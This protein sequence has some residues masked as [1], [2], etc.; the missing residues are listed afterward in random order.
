MTA[1]LAA[2]LLTVLAGA[3]LW[4]SALGEPGPAERVHEIAA[5]LRCPDC[6]G[7][8]A[9]ESSSQMALSVRAEIERRL[10]AGQSADAILDHF[11]QRYGEWIRLSPGGDGLS[12]LLWILPVAALAAALLPAVRRR[13]GRGASAVLSA[14]PRPGRRGSAV[15]PAV[16]RRWASRVPDLPDAEHPPSAG[17]SRADAVPAVVLLLLGSVAVTGGAVAVWASGRIQNAPVAEETRGGGGDAAGRA[18][19]LAAAGDH[20]AAV[21]AYREALRQRPDDRAARYLMAFEL[22]RSGR[23]AEA[24]ALL[25]PLLATRPH[26]PDLL[27]VLGTAE[28]TTDPARGR[29]TLRRFLAAAPQGHAAAPRI[30]A[31]LRSSRDLPG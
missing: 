19:A 27:L 10:R 9:A 1:R 29:R 14:V 13:R 31:L 20:D 26:D 22:V 28:L 23:A 17:R 18:R 25:E 7:V 21:R 3:A 4:R 30:R 16:R 5:S 6:Q 2:L 8:S 24:V 12:A 15:L 11:R